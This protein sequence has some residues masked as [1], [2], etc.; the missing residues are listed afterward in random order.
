[1]ARH[2]LG[3]RDEQEAMVAKQLCVVP[4]V[5]SPLHMLPMLTSL[6]KHLSKMT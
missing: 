2:S 3:F 4:V 5:G 1:M 6:A